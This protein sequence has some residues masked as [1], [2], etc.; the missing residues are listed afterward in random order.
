MGSIKI[1]LKIVSA[2]VLLGEW[3]RGNRIANSRCIENSKEM[4]RY[5]GGT[6]E[7]RRGPSTVAC[8][9]LMLVVKTFGPVL[10]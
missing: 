5:I 3:G 6:K 4:E 9:F 1:R 2:A 7:I 8:S 10:K